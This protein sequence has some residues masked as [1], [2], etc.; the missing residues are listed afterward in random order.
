LPANTA[1]HCQVLEEGLVFKANDVGA[2]MELVFELL[3]LHKGHYGFDAELG[4]YHLE[5]RA[6]KCLSQ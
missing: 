1:L 4:M 2:V 5:E 6:F 3:Q